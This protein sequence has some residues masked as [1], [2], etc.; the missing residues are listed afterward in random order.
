MGCRLIYEDD[1][2]TVQLYNAVN[3]QLLPLND[4]SLGLATAL[5]D[6][7]DPNVFLLS[8]GQTLFVFLYLPI[9]LQGPG[10]PSAVAVGC[11][12]AAAVAIALLMNTIGRH[13]HCRE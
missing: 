8:D 6:A 5:W 7:V 10:E 2:H 12:V 13:Y 3:D 9:S 4:V 1:K 11:T